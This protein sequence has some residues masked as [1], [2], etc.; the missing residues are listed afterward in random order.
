MMERGAGGGGWGDVRGTGET[1]PDLVLFAS[2]PQWGKYSSTLLRVLALIDLHMFLLIQNVHL[3]LS[4]GE[5][6]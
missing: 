3:D 6:Y 1:L 2:R 4:D 5:I